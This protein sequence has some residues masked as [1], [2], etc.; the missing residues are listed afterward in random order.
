MIVLCIEIATGFNGSIS[1][2]YSRESLG[3]SEGGLNPRQLV[4]YKIQERSAE[5][6]KLN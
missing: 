6:R 2:A 3:E 5:T 1:V 4:G